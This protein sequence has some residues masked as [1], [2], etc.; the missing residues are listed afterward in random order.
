MAY[1]ESKR[2]LTFEAGQDLSAK[3]FFFVTVAADGQVDPTGDG[4]FADGVLQ[5]DP[6][7]AGKAAEVAVGEVIKVQCG[8]AVTAGDDVAA[9][10]NGA[11]VTAATGDIIMGKALEAASGAGSQIAVLF[12]YRGTAA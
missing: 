6:D 8:A 5:N 10:A 9:D 7:A 11:A 2:S 1:Q 12:G 3:Q 4:L